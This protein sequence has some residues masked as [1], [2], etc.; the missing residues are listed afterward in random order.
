M[1]GQD[2]TVGVGCLQAG[3]V[4]VEG[5]PSSRMYAPS[6]SAILIVFHLAAALGEEVLQH[7]DAGGP[8]VAAAEEVLT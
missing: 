3:S 2:C 7:L 1:A 5:I 4:E 6:C 8:L